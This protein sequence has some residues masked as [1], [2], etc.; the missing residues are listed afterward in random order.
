[1]IR[2]RKTPAWPAKN[3]DPHFLQG[4]DDVLA[5]SPRVR[6]GL[7]PLPHVVP[8]VNTMTEMFRKTPIDVTTDGILPLVGVKDD[9]DL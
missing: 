5:D 4:F 1:M 7:V 6:Y 8:S 9:P 2:V 3:W